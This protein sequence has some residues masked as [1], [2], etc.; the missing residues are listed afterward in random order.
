WAVTST[1]GGAAAE[2]GGGARRRGPK[3]KLFQRHRQDAAMEAPRS[4]EK[5]EGR[6]Q[7]NDRLYA[8]SWHARARYDVSHLHGADQ[9]RLRLG[10]RHGEEAAGIDLAAAG[11]DGV[12]RQLAVHRG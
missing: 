10:S 2:L 7:D 12:V 8:E 3:T 11:C 1:I 5:A 4:P 9:S 6:L